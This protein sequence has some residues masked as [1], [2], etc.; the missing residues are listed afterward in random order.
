[1]KRVKKIGII[2]IIVIIMVG[3]IGGVFFKKSKD[4]GN[5]T[6]MG[7]VVE[8]DGTVYYN[9]YEKGIFAY[10]NGNEKRLTD[11]T[12]Y[13]LTI[14]EDKI[15][16]IT[17]ADFSNVVIKSV[18]LTGENLKNVA[19]IYTSFSK[20]FIQD[21]FIY[22]ST[23]KGNK[24]IAR[25]DLNGENET[26][27]LT[28]NIQDFQLVKN[29]IFYT[30]AQ[31]Q[32][33]KISLSRGNNEMLSQE[34]TAKK[35]QVVG[36]WIYY[37]D[38]NENALFR[39][40]KNGKKKELVSILVKNETYNVFG[41]YVYFLDKE[42][43]KITRMKIGKSNQCNDIVTLSISNTKIN[44]AEDELY[45]LDKSKDEGQIYQMCRVKLNGD[46]AKSIEY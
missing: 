31:N 21:H 34:V 27:I 45:Y 44:I 39:L 4:N 42:N 7:L 25:M 43:A 38:E 19:T 12:A 3:I 10:R 2:G 17:V 32:I 46:E 6:N 15:Y 36:K 9:K 11:E 8:K 30:N 23:N 35:I 40:T 22:Y 26:M 28:E 20:F 13:C 14:F 1:M 33:G 41:K 5:V 18:D 16:Y 37:Y 29:E 24:G